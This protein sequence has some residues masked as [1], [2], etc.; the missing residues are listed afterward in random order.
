MPNP[1][2]SQA[3]VRSLAR[4]PVAVRD[5]R[6]LIGP[7]ALFL[8]AA[9]CGACR[10]LPTP[11]PTP[12]TQHPSPCCRI[13]ELRQYTL[14]PGQRDTLIDLFDSEFVDTQEATGMRII[15]QFR[16]LDDAARFVWLR[17]FDDM[18][19]RARALDAFYSGPVWQAHR[20]A[21]NA[22]IIDSDNVLL[23]QPA[24]ATAGFD[25]GGLVRFGR[26]AGASARGIVVATLLDFGDR[27]DPG[28]GAYFDTQMAP[29]LAQSGIDVLARL[30]TEPAANTYP[31]LPVRAGAQVF[32]WIAR[33]DDA[34][35]HAHRLAEL[36]RNAHWRAIQARLRDRGVDV[37]TLRLAPTSR[38]LIP[39]PVR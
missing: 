23:L 11:E 15:G 31:R 27:G 14:Q 18:P 21:A 5:D 33:Y 7:I 39:A 32:V 24:G 4:R 30:I 3:P 22:T 1:T 16:D 10:T 34:A 37:Q 13:I 38:S 26:D 35:D 12:M 19:A 20:N 28:F 6:R 2:H 9:L 25:L 8:S 29:L 17:G 36:E